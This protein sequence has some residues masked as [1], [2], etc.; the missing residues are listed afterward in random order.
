MSRRNTLYLLVAGLFLLVFAGAVHAHAATRTVDNHAD[1][2]SPG[3]LR[4]EIAQAQSGD[5]IAITTSSTIVLSNGQI[6]ISTNLTIQAQTNAIAIVDGDDLSRIFN[7]TAASVTLARLQLQNGMDNHGGAVFSFASDLT[8]RDCIVTSNVSPV[9]GGGLYVFGGSL[10]LRGSI[11]HHNDTDDTGGAV[12]TEDAETFVTSCSFRFNGN[13]DETAAGAFHGKGGAHLICDSEFTRNLSHGRG[14]NVWLE[15]AS[16]TIA[17]CNIWDNE[18]S[19]DGM[20]VYFEL[21]NGDARFD[22]INTRVTSNSLSSDNAVSFDVQQ[23]GRVEA[24]FSDCL[25]TNITSASHGAAIQFNVS[26]NAG[27]ELVLTRCTFANNSTGGGGQGGAINIQTAGAYVRIED[28][29]I[30]NNSA[31]RGGGIYFSG[32]NLGSTLEIVDSRITGNTAT[33]DFSILGGGAIYAVDDESRLI[34][35]GCHIADNT[36]PIVDGGGIVT[37]D[38]MELLIE[39]STIVGNTCGAAGGGL[40]VDVRTKTVTIASCTIASNRADGQNGGGI[41]SNAENVLITSS[42]VTG[43]SAAGYGGGLYIAGGAVTVATTSIAGNTSA[44]R[45][46][47]FYVDQGALDVVNSSM[48]T[49][50]AN[51]GAVGYFNGSGP[52][53]ISFVDSEIVTNG[54][55]CRGGAIYL[56]GAPSTLRLDGV[57]IEDNATSSEGGAVFMDNGILSV[58]SSTFVNNRA[59][60]GTEGG[61]LSIWGGDADFHGTTFANNRSNLNGGAIYNRGGHLEIAHCAFTGNVARDGHGGGIT[62]WNGSILVT[63][64]TFSANTASDN[65]GGFAAVAASANLFNSTFS[66]NEAGNLGGGVYSSAPDIDIASCTITANIADSD[67]NGTGDGGGLWAATDIFFSNLIA[68]NTDRGGE[69]P[70][71]GAVNASSGYNLIGDVGQYNFNA[72]TTGDRY[73]D[74]NGIV[75]PNAGAFESASAI[76]AKLEPLAD[77][78]GFGHTHALQVSSPAFGSSTTAGISPLDQRGEPRFETPDIGA[79]E[80]FVPLTINAPASICLGTTTKASVGLPLPGASYAWSVF[81]GAFVAGQNTTCASLKINSL[82]GGRVTLTETLAL[83]GIRTTSVTFS[84]VVFAALDHI[85]LSEGQTVEID[86][87]ANDSGDNLSIV[88]TNGATGGSV[89]LSTTGTLLYVS[90]GNFSGCDT[91]T[92]QLRD[93]LG[94]TATGAVIVNVLTDFAN[95][96]ELNFIERKKDRSGGVRGLRRAYDVAASPDGKHVYAVGRSDHSIAT[97]ARNDSSGRLSYLGRKRHGRQGVKRM[98]YPEAL[99]I[100]PDGNYVYVVSYLDNSIVVFSRDANSGSLSYVEHQRQGQN[101]VDG[102]QRPRG[103]AISSDGANVYVAAF[104]GD[105]LAVFARKTNDGTLQFIEHFKDNTNGVDGLN[106]A[107]SVAASLDGSSV[108]VAGFNDNAIAQFDRS[109]SNGQLSYRKLYRDGVAGV[110]GLTGA[111]SVVVSADAG[112][113]YAVGQIDDA[114]ATFGRDKGTGDLTF[115]ARI[116]DGASGAEGLNGA[117]D[118]ALSK[119]G[120]HLYVTGEAD[121]ALGAFVRDLDNGALTPAHTAFDG[122]NGVDGLR[123]ATAVIVTDD[124]KHIYAAARG[125]NA[126]SA[127]EPNF[128]PKGEH[129]TIS[130]LRTETLAIAQVF[131]T[132]PEDQP[133]TVQSFTNGAFGNVSLIIVFPVS[134]TTSLI[135]FNYNV[136]INDFP[137]SFTYTLANAYGTAT[138]TIRVVEKFAKSATPTPETSMVIE[139]GPSPSL[140]LSVS[141]N[142]VAAEMTMSFTLDKDAQVELGIYDLRGRL[143][144]ALPSMTLKAGRHN[145][146]WDGA[147]TSAV[148]LTQGSYLLSLRARDALGAEIQGQTMVNIVR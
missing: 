1:D 93:G 24:H 102:M 25:I 47:A 121:N 50:S 55:C 70:D 119:D 23:S 39:E 3:T 99:A 111:A 90:D 59:A 143:V 125:D 5:I 17:N 76:D 117:R 98:R 74:P 64:S 136:V 2:G 54:T 4:Y 129:K 131:A 77:N 141:P 21:R 114:V 106:G 19:G 71:I 101:G 34:V 27:S 6:D 118:L 103:L 79:F 67:N 110:D 14:V 116:R 62:H 57:H 108:Y 30:R 88:T 128:V 81:N 134:P 124:N 13:T 10:E 109:L 82:V 113:V 51:N 140:D 53:L 95:N 80:L 105:A 69:C 16:A 135:Q 91:F 63:S 122:Q 7:I 139:T 127:F 86:V 22:M 123:Q 75:T 78:G 66:G 45:G 126:V 31:G 26:D 94:C 33:Q 83:G 60:S 35:R 29:D 120:A 133:I 11:L 100:S 56:T 147:A 15:D 58:T 12:Y 43:N 9:D 115:N 8:V 145:I 40:Y 28:C 130:R 146:T 46:G 73:G 137:D 44:S 85:S 112:F 89:S 41:F 138:Y 18:G 87:L 37:S 144:A 49:N 148:R 48:R 32:T 38:L 104:S 52:S 132:F 20:A 97:F 36:A 142:P 42:T 68:D 96:V 84:A 65:G 61:A 72:N 107:I 92:Y